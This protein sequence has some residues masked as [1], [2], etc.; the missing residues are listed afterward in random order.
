MIDWITAVLPWRHRSEISAGQV[1]KRREDGSIEW[2]V[3]SRKP[4]EGSHDSKIHIKSDQRTWDDETGDFTHLVFD[5]N[6]VKFLQGHNIWGS[7][8]LIGLMSETVLCLSEVL[9]LPIDDLDWRRVTSGKYRVHRVDSTIMTYLDNLKSVDA[10]LYAAER[11]SRMRF[12]GQGI[13]KKG[14][15]Y[16]SPSSR[17]ESL[18]M[19]AKGTEIRAR[20]HELPKALQNLSHLYSWADSRLRVEVCLRTLELKDRGLH[21]ASSWSLDTPNEVVLKALGKLEMSDTFTLPDDKFNALS[22]KLKSTYLLWQRGDDLSLLLSKR[23]FYRHRA[24]LLKQ[25]G[26]D[27]AILQPKEKPSNVVEFRRVLS[28]ILDKQVP[29]WAIGTDLFF[30]PRTVVPRPTGKKKA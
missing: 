12:K 8:D 3:R 25:F 1:I 24:E 2:T 27:I 30:E 17:R 18:K 9:D 28:P 23:T 6:P 15:L 7:D 20:G 5:G 16:F 22:H 26:I 11:Q 19:Y 10:F 29:D 21:H 14:T 13:M 4:I